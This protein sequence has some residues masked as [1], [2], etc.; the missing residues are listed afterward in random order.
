MKILTFHPKSLK[1]AVKPVALGVGVTL[2]FGCATARIVSVEPGVGGEISI[3]PSTSEEAR[4]KASELMRMNCGSKKPRITKE[5]EVVVGQET[6]SY[7][8]VNSRKRGGYSTS[9]SSYTTNSTEW[10]LNYKCE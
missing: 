6:R 2:L 10:R 4:A 9:E 7:G 5:G 8:D 3:R 1:S